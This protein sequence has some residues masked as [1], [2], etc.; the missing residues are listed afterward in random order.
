MMVVFVF[1][2]WHGS[3]GNRLL[4]M[5]RTFI[6][7]PARMIRVRIILNAQTTLLPNCRLA[8]ITWG[9]IAPI[10]LPPLLTS[11]RAPGIRIRA[12]VIDPTGPSPFVFSGV[13]RLLLALLH[14]I[15][16][17]L[18]VFS[19]AQF[20]LRFP[21]SGTEAWYL[22]RNV[23]TSARIVN[24]SCRT[25]SIS[26]S[27]INTLS[28]I[29]TCSTVNSVSVILLLSKKP[30]ICFALGYGGAAPIGKSG[31]EWGDWF[32]VRFGLGKL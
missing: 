14:P 19:F 6:L 15:V 29:S 21:Q 18:V 23:S 12:F 20:V 7:P 2:L 31:W 1:I 24:I 26:P 4:L 10:A 32:S 28:N 16:Q 25:L 17:V 5:F 13:L 11:L 3:W 27:R 8:F 22:S 9:S 30:W